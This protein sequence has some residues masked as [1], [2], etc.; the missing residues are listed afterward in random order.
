MNRTNQTIFGTISAIFTLSIACFMCGKNL[1]QAEQGGDHYW[2]HGC[3][4]GDETL[5]IAGG[6]EAASIDLATGATVKTVPMYVE[7]VTC[8]EKDGIAWASSDEQVKFPEGVRGPS[9]QSSTQDVVGA[10][11]DG[12]LVRFAREKD[13]K[14]RPRGWGRVSVGGSPEVALTP[15][16][17]GVLGAARNAPVS[18]FLNRVGPVMPDGRLL[19]AAGWLPYSDQPGVWGLYAVEPLSGQVAPIAGPIPAMKALD[20]SKLWVLT[21]SRDQKLGAAAFRGENTTR[22]ALFEGTNAR[23]TI[24]IAGAREPTALD[25]S[26]AGDRL[27]VATLSEDGS[28]AKVT[29]LETA[30]GK[31]AWAS[32]ALDGTAY[33]VRHL[34]DASL[35]IMTSKRV[36]KRVSATGNSK[37]P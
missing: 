29:W 22:V 32:E 7:T 14:G 34:A 2:T 1:M 8:G 23:W 10:R 20:T 26:P 11:G 5:L 15:D 19:L 31:V 36:V 37:W 18:Q 4:T 25:F 13:N 6:D 28:Q 12:A 27:A 3:V 16:H 33:L 24:E 9:S 30:D 21:A 17:F 35:V